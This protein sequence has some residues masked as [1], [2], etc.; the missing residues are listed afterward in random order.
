MAFGAVSCAAPAVPAPLPPVSTLRV[1]MDNNYPPYV[2]RDERGQLRGILVDQWKLWEERTGVKVEITALPWG[3]ALGRMKAGEFD[4]IDTIFRTAERDEIFSFTKTYAQINVR[5]FFQKNISGLATAEDLKGFRVAV[6]TG[7]ADVDYLLE[8]G[9]KNLIYYDS[10]EEIVKAAAAKEE[11]IFVIDEPPALYY[12]YKNQ[13]NGEFS[14]SEPLYSGEFHR[15]VKKGD[16]ALLNLVTDGFAQITPAEYQ[17]IN[18]RWLGAQRNDLWQGFVY[19]L[20]LGISILSLLLLALFF[21]NRVLQSRVSK[22]TQ[23]LEAALSSLQKSETRFRESIEFLPIPISLFRQDGKILLV[24]QKFTQNYGYLLEDVPT[25]EAWMIQAYPDLQE[26]E[27]NAAVWGEDVAQALREEKSTPLREYLVTCKDGSRRSVEIVMHPVGGLW[28]AVFNNITERKQTEE[29]LR[30]NE[31][32]FS[33]FLEH[34]PVYVF[35]KDKNIRPL[36]LSKNYEKMLGMPVS[37]A[38]GKTMDELFPSDLSKSMVADDLRI[39]TEGRRVDVVEKLNGR[40]YET[41]KFPIYKDGEPFML[42]GFTVD[43]TDRKL[44]EEALRESES[45]LRTVTENAPDT[46]MQ[47]SR[48]G[49]ILF[50]N[51][52]VPGL[53]QES[54]LS[55]SIYQWVP[56]EQHPVLSQALETVFRTGERQE[57]ESFGP[58]PNGTTRMYDVRVMPVM[59]AGQASSAIYNATDITERKQMVDQL[60]ASEEQYRTLIETVNVGIFMTTLDGKFLQANSAVVKMAGYDD[61]DEFI[62]LPAQALYAN[63]T[64]RERVIIELRRQG[65][66]KNL[67]IA[68]VKKNGAKYWISLSA[69]FLKDAAGQPLSILGSVIDITERKHSAEVLLQSEK[70]FRTLIENSADALTLLNADGTVFYEGPTVKRLTGYSAADRLGKSSFKDVFPEDVSAVQQAIKQLL[71]RPGAST[72]LQFR[73][74]RADGSIWWTDGTVTNLL[75]DPSVQAIVV[76]YRDITKRKLAEEALRKSYERNYAIVAALPDLLFELSADGRFLD[77]IASDPARFLIPPDQA[78]GRR[79]DEVL[80]SDLAALTLQKIR[81]T[82]LSAE[83]QV[84]EYSILVNQTTEFYESRMTPLSPD[85]VLALVRDITERKWAE[86]ALRRSEA[87]VRS[88]NT[89]LEQRVAERTAQL[90]LANQELEAFS[91]SVSHDLRAPLRAIDGFSRIVLEDFAPR[92]EP[93]VQRLL[94]HIRT[95]SHHMTQLIEAL[96]NLSRMS[97]AEMRLETVNLSV[98]AQLILDGFH[99]VQPQRQVEFVVASDLTVQGDPRLL[100]VALENLLG[101]AWKF[102]SKR[103]RAKIEFGVEDRENEPVY[104]VRDNGAGFDMAY[105]NKLFGVF[106]R[107]HGANE[108]EG[109]GIGLTTVQRIIHRHGGRVWVEAA[110]GQGATFYFTL[111]QPALPGDSLPF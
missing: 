84:Y 86:D 82:L 6:K 107:L 31:V 27:K 105:A 54:V 32:I 51:R 69:V 70:R 23:E 91:Y 110:V 53:T 96:L 57:Y 79:V 47:V 49:T 98:L 94:D 50:V 104:F 18:D 43:V 36:R 106:Q 60:K 65:F 24:N 40:I 30:E 48:Q 12:L 9:V 16:E 42:A 80:P 26:R 20:L 8:H 61:P 28:V 52:L 89:E 78:I 100:S 75:H 64:D 39:L 102:T 44:A 83:M 13:I 34:S 3:E 66:I 38:L 77:C 97:R 109:T 4:V 5:I 14:F 22:R 103:E 55:T 63:S 17:T 41:T 33:S 62:L 7:D 88:L 87:E 1:V 76:N 72:N 56:E 101:N 81:L 71:T 111:G 11:T 19:P 58:G 99:Q 21:F 90:E 29:A 37:E 35:F 68:S 93:E 25:I 15:A 95:E 85:S 73:S 46:I 59:I 74:I 2:F 108:F 45:R 10:Y 92:L 67:E